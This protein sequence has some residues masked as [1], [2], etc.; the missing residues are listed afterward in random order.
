MR[1]LPSPKGVDA[2]EVEHELHRH[3]QR[4]DPPGGEPLAQR[5]AQAPTASGVAT[6]GTGRNLT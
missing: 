4:V 5:G 6:A 2:G 1:P 3:E